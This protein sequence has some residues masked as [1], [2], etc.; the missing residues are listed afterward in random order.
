M[1]TLRKTVCA[2][3]ALLLLVGML[4]AAALADGGIWEGPVSVT[5]VSHFGENGLLDSSATYTDSAYYSDRWFL[6]DSAT[7]NYELAL[8][9]AMA[10]GASSSS[11]S[12]P[13]GRKISALL[14]AMHFSG[15]E[16]NEYYI[17][18]TSERDSIGC[19]IGRKTITDSAGKA[20][21]LLAVFF[22]NA[23]YEYEW[24]SNFSVGEKRTNH[25]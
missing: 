12:D 22:R 16:R 5:M 18:G 10:C 11:T 17:N 3:L 1:K 24:I 15:V 9:S 2:L 19:I 14:E 6:T 7:T 13:Y 21:T 25:F 8:M 20:H 4:P 23:G